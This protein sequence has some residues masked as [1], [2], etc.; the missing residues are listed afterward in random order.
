M[1]LALVNGNKVISVFGLIIMFLMIKSAP[2]SAYALNGV[3]I[4]TNGSSQSYEAYNNKILIVDAT[5]SWC[6]SCDPQL[7]E[8]QEVYNLVDSRI[9]IL[10]LSVDTADT[11]TKMVGLKNK[12]TSPWTFGID[13]SSDFQSKYPVAVLPTLHI[14]DLEGNFYS[15]Y[16]GVTSANT[17][18]TQVNL[19]LSNEVNNEEEFVPFEVPE[20]RTDQSSAIDNLFSNRLFIFAIPVLLMLFAFK[21]LSPNRVDT[22]PDDVISKTTKTKIADRLRLENQWIEKPNTTKQTIKKKQKKKGKGKSVRSIDRS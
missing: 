5:A 17:I 1:K 7:I 21:F 13:K 2:S 3:F 10:T 22:S 19:I 11:P 9:K 14:F 4:D 8:L 15:K 12:F 18:M 20:A 16:E 6:T